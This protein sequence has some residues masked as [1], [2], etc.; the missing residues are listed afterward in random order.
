MK[1]SEKQRILSIVLLEGIVTL[2]GVP[3]VIVVKTKWG[4]SINLSYVG[5]YPF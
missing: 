3:I 4:R 2:K 5:F 1:I